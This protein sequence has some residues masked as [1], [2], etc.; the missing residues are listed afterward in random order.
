MKTKKIISLLLAVMMIVAVIPAGIIS[1]AAAETYT[2]PF[3]ND[4]WT[5][6]GSGVKVVDG[7]TFTSTPSNGRI[8]QDWNAVT[9]KFAIIN[10]F[11][12]T[13]AQSYDLSN[14]F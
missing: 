6:T 10:L 7:T 4:S 9:G 8:D 11:S 14:G 2:V 13:T 12:A 3:T 1:V 5:T